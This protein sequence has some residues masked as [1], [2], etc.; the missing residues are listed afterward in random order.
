MIIVIL[1]IAFLIVFIVYYYKKKILADKMNITIGENFYKYIR[2]L[3]K[4]NFGSVGLY[5]CA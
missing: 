2:E 4:G 1:V 5:K 3:G